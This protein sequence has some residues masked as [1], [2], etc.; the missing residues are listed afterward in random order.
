MEN[1]DITNGCTASNSKRNSDL[2]IGADSHPSLVLVY[3]RKLVQLTLD[4]LDGKQ[5]GLP[6]CHRHVVNSP[7]QCLVCEL[8]NDI[9]HELARR[10]ANP[11][12]LA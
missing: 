4:S 5:S 8:V 7:D 1:N 3:G 10:D 6:L 12:D 2:Q 9:R 11:D